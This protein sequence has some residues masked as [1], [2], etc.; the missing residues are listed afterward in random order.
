MVIENRADGLHICGYVNAT[1]K[2]SRPVITPHGKVIEVVEPRA[3]E[4][5]IERAGNVTVTLDHD[6]THIYA[7]T[8][9]NSLTLREDDIGLHADVLIKDE[10]II[11]L[12]NK[13]KI[14]GWSFGMYNVKD[15][16]EKRGEDL[17][18]RH[19]KDLDLD[20]VSL[21]AHMTPVY[22]ATSVEIRGEAETD[23]EQRGRADEIN[24]TQ[25]A[26]D[27]SGPVFYNTELM[28]KKFNLLFGGKK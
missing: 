21:I 26:E 14:R 18:I 4:R 6:M 23:I 19:I 15:E 24:K 1:E 3:F 12:A 11:E 5:A 27:N 28:Q 2:K 20:H 7:E 10:S 22:S 25:A 17:P 13:G 8:S 16:L 9:D